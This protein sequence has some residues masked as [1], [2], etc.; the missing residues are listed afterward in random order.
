MDAAFRKNLKNDEWVTKEFPGNPTQNLDHVRKWI[1]DNPQAKCFSSHTALLPPPEIDGIKVLPVIFIRHPVDRIASAYAFERRQGGTSFGAV[2][3]RN[4]GLKG[5]IET[6]L[7]LPND[8]QC[9]NFH[10]DR[11]ASMFPADCGSEL[12]RAK[13]AVQNLPFV[14]LVED[15]DQS[16]T[17]LERIISAFGIGDLNLSAVRKNVTRDTGK[18][19]ED[20][21][22]DI[23]EEVGEEFYKEILEINAMDIS[24]Y[25]YLTNPMNKPLKAH[26]SLSH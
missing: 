7:S 25:K 9:R 23:Q 11:L 13:M 19:L 26:P 1:L 18:S 17:R 16:T 6:R 21:L 14:G 2:L 3:A 5:Y 12:E 22:E 15:F 10:V 24:L 4:T 8:R 20:K